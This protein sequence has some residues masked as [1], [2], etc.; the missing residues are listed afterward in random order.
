MTRNSDDDHLKEPE[1]PLHDY[2]SLPNF[3]FFKT[4]NKSLKFYLL[5]F[6]EKIHLCDCCVILL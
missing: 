5:F 6:C 3:S 4:L 1:T 2:T